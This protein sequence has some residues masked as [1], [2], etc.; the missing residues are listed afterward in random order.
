MTR[1]DGTALVYVDASGIHG[2]GLFAQQTIPAGTLIGRY[3]GR[4]T[5]ENG[6]HVLWIEGQGNGEWLGIDGCND[7][8]FVN[9]SD[10][11]NCEM[12]GQD[13]YAARDVG[14]GEEIT[15]YYGDEFS[16]DLQHPT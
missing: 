15:I 3:E 16:A 1:T 8:R 7:L 5:R 2:R 11:P 13:L 6:T 4:P 10:Q 9:H 12:D 14:A